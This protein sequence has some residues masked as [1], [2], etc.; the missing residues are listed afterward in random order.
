ME[1]VI[2]WNKRPSR[3]LAQA[4][5]RI[6]VDSLLQAERVEEELLNTILG[7]IDNP[8]KYPL[9]KFKK[10]NPGQYRAF[11]KLSFRVTYKVTPTQIRIL[12]IRHVKQEPKEY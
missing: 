7:V 6:S 3:F 1:R 10:N 8:E 4:L 5:K 12:R 11:E 9:D 2:V